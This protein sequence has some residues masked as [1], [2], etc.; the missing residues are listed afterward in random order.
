MKQ[1]RFK[2][3]FQIG[4]KNRSHFKSKKPPKIRPKW[5][6]NRLQKWSKMG[7]YIIAFL[8]LYKVELELDYGSGES[9]EPALIWWL[10]GREQGGGE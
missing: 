10:G 8:D 6:Q 9:S 2:M 1:N 3:R 4:I 7:F 5:L